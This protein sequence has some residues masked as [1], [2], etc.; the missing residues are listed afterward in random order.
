MSAM[1]FENGTKLLFYKTINAR[2]VNLVEVRA[3]INALSNNWRVM[4]PAIAD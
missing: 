4:N 3:G 1:C 2:R